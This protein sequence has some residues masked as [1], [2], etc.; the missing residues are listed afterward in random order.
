[1]DAPGEGV[2]LHEE[3]MFCSHLGSWA[4]VGDPQEQEEASFLRP[5]MGASSKGPQA[6]WGLEAPQ[7]QPG[8]LEAAEASLTAWP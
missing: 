2:G 7:L 6:G 8:P 5:A 4:Q 3:G 1:M